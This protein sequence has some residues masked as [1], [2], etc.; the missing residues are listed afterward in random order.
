MCL[1]EQ[2]QVFARRCRKNSLVRSET[3]DF[4][5]VKIQVIVQTLKRNS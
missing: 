2:E 3:I 1:A 4:S 5:R